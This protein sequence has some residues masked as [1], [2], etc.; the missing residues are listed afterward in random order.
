ML[1]V[2]R[3]FPE[4]QTCAQG[5]PSSS[6]GAAAGPLAADKRSERRRHR[7]CGRWRGDG[8][9]AWPG[10]LRAGA[11]P[12]RAGSGGAARLKRRVGR[13][14]LRA[15]LQLAPRIPPAMDARARAKRYEKLDFLGEGQVRH[16]GGGC[17]LPWGCSSPAGPGAGCRPPAA[18]WGLEAA[19][20][21]PPRA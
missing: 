10:P 9:C 5:Q 12:R 16:R 20:P 1:R 2:Y 8:A 15:S 7:N 6:S 18:G 14:L 19:G 17:P 13:P 11:G 3:N 21:C 4:C